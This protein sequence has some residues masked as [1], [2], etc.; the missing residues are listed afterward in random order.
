MSEGQP[1]IN[2]TYTDHSGRTL[3][4]TEL[5]R[6]N[7]AGREVIGK[8]TDDVGTDGISHKYSCT[9]EMWREIWRDKKAP[10]DP[11]RMKIG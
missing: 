3:V 2:A 11:S 9:L 1:D 5:Q 4:V 6:N 7:P 8:V 10:I